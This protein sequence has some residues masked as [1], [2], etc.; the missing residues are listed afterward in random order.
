[1]P[2]KQHSPM[3]NRGK[4]VLY[5]VIQ[6]KQKYKLGDF[7]FWK[8]NN[9]EFVHRKWIVGDLNLSEVERSEDLFWLAFSHVTPK[10][11]KCTN[12]CL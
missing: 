4:R 9:I 11:A 5:L 2:Q 1:M 8:L 6:T 3:W 7:L 12:W 10:Q